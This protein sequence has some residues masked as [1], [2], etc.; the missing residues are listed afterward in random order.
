MTEYVDH[1]AFYQAAA[2][3]IRTARTE[4]RVTFVR[5]YPPTQYGSPEAATYFDA[6]LQWASDHAR[7]SA[8][9]RRIIAVPERE[10]V[11]TLP[12]FEWLKEHQREVRDLYAYE[13]RVIPW[14]AA[15]DW[16]NMALIDDS[17]TFLAFSGVG[18]QQLNGLSVEGAMFLRNFADGFDHAWGALEPID[19]YLARHAA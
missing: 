2:E 10:S 19:S 15:C 14:N 7:H 17:T 11:A 1:P 3:C 18:R 16:F 8:S 12:M 6:I 13:A 4:I 9:A 5:Q